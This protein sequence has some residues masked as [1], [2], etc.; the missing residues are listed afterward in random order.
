MAD[1]E[2]AKGWE[3]ANDGWENAKEETTSLGENFALGFANVGNT[4]DTAASMLAAAL[5]SPFSQDKADDI[6]RKSEQANKER[7]DWA[8][9]KGK[10]QSFGGKIAG[11]LNPLTLPAQIATSMLSPFQTGKTAIDAGETIPTAIKA[12]A[13]DSAGNFAG[14]AVPVGG[15]AF[16]PVVNTSLGFIA[17]AG[18]DAITKDIINRK[19]LQTEAGKEAIKPTAEDAVVSGILG[20]TMTGAA[21]QWKIKPRTDFDAKLNELTDKKKAAAAPDSTVY[22]GKDKTAT[23]GPSTRIEESP[24][25]VALF[26]ALAEEK[27]AKERGTV[28]VDSKGNATKELPKQIT[29]DPAI[30][31][32]AR[33]AQ[34]Q[35]LHDRATELGK[36]TGETRDMFPEGEQGNL[37]LGALYRDGMGGMG[38]SQRGAINLPDIK[39]AM[40]G[41]KNKTVEPFEY[42][43]LWRGAFT[44]N[45][46]GM[47]IKSLTNPK[48]RDTVVLMSPDDFHTLAA[49]RSE[50]ELKADYTPRL[51]DSI[52][53]GLKSREGL[54]EMPY[55]MVDG[56]NQVVSHE[57]RH[58]MDVFKE[59]GIDL[60]PVRLRSKEV[61]WSERKPPLTM[62][63]QDAK[64]YSIEGKLASA[65][66]APSFIKGQEGFTFPSAGGMGRSQRG[67]IDPDLLTFGLASKLGKRLEKAKALEESIGQKLFQESTNPENVVAAALNEGK[68]GRGFNNLEAGATLAAEKRGSA[69]IKG[70]S[71]IV[72]RA[73]NIAENNV[74][75]H[76]FPVEKS[77]RGLSLEG[78]E[79]LAKVMKQ[80]MFLGQQFDMNELASLGLSE[81]QMIAYN[82][83]RSMFDEALRAQNVAREARGLPII[84]PQEAYLSSRWQGDFR[85]AVFDKKGKL[86]WYLAD[87]T[88]SGLDKQMKAL[89]SEFPELQKG[90]SQDHTVR[91]LNNG[92]DIH[93]VYT[94]M[95]DVLG[96]DNP[97]VQDI[98]QWYE[99]KLAAESEKAFAQ[100]KHFEDKNNIRGFVGDRP[101]KNPRREAIDMFQ[102]QIMYAKN[103]FK[104]AELQQAG[105]GLKTIFGNEK[106]QAQQP[107]NMRYA[108]DYYA[109]QLGLSTNQ[110]VRA[111]EQQL[112]DFN[113]SPKTINDTIGSIKNLWITQKLAVS[114][115][116]MASNVIQAANVL[117]HLMDLQTKF[118][119]NPLNILASIGFALPVGTAMAT[120]HVVNQA[121]AVRK[122]F[123]SLPLPN[124]FLLK[125]MKYAE[126]NSVTARS[127]YDESP[128]ANTFTA[129]GKASNIL[130]KTISTPETF[131]RSF[132]YLAYATQLKL[133]GKFKNDMDIF[134]LAEERTNISMGDY[135]EG[136][137][138]LLF[139]KM[140]TVGNAVNVLQT[141]P[142]NYYNQWSWAIRE[143][144]KGN[145]APAITMFAVQALAAGA[146]G[147]PGFSDADKL[148]NAIK[149]YLAEAAPTY[150]N[151]VK[152]LDLKAM[153]LNTFGEAGLYGALST[154]S[155]VA[156]TSRAAAPAG[157]EMLQNPA[158]PFL[159]LGEQAMNIGKSL[160]DPADSQKRAQAMLGSAPVGLQGYLET[161]PLRDET[162]VPSGD[163]SRVYKTR[164]LA[165]REGSVRRDSSQETIRA[166]GLRSQKEVLEKDAAYTARKKEAQTQAVVRS[167]PDK[168]YNAV[169]KGDMESAREYM[170][171]YS[172]LSGNKMTEQ[173]F[174]NRILKEYTAATDKAST[175]AQT[176]EGLLAVKRLREIL[177]EQQ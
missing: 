97:Y 32:A 151:K 116:F 119:G 130:G 143:S 64:N 26:K 76:V 74:R 139:N 110:V 34:Q 94:T 111:L 132:T 81:K 86:V 11:A 168:F 140:G 38:R 92:T 167:L 120:G 103:A 157:S 105:E 126:D 25:M 172:Q 45:E 91:S 40:E 165:D 8:N 58:R 161:G 36:G 123:A 138:A 102:Q 142:I 27:T 90:S 19:I 70:V 66:P 52:K 137:R 84:T 117:P 155:G 131:L 175:K 14:M 63:P 62:F 124:E 141:F 118:G 108:Q 115:G 100:T 21:Q 89:L 17:N 113:I 20:A 48:S 56:N 153:V 15:P 47:A 104:W 42:L 98:K 10:K 31:D 112:K 18:Q 127:I 43:K 13:V 82:N 114:A 23:V 133:S 87:N 55:L 80:E 79:Q 134:R 65:V 145:A 53:E 88:K 136:E 29:E 171:L 101:G 41:V 158:A 49:K 109:D 3:T 51:R 99:T 146:M 85:R 57:G 68:D 67:I 6:L 169:R 22:V 9:P 148:V 135:R 173:M 166:L 170:T 39:R 1:W 154:E 2:D 50:G 129:T 163:G 60:V 125:M 46:L 72:Q 59:Q 122:A 75:T 106:L 7:L 69:L 83:I 147:V 4:A 78:I 174:K 54:W 93:S 33:T 30:T 77:L 107:N 144:L 24:E 12:Q 152:D 162:S 159:D 121:S 160:I 71:R 35:I 5:V 128:V 44:D 37:D 61:P 73:K 176:V 164:N 150:W 156:M 95:L 28:F 177:A 96:S 16:G 149:D